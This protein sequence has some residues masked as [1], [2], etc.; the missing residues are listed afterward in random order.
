M[1][2]TKPAQKRAFWGWLWW[3][4]V[5]LFAVGSVAYHAWVSIQIR[6]NDYEMARCRR[7]MEAITAEMREVK[8]QMA[9][10]ED[11]DA[12]HAT[13]EEL[14]LRAP[15]PEQIVRLAFNPAEYVPVDERLQAQQPAPQET[16]AEAGAPAKKH[17]PQPAMELA[18]I[19]L[20]QTVAPRETG[21]MTMALD[22]DAALVPVNMNAPAASAVVE[23]AEHGLDGS[24]DQ[25]LEKF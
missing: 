6:N 10:R 12:V 11:M 16:P 5:L 20:R 2:M 19:E 25:M 1:R 15:R 17:K 4:P 3:S 18:K 22:Y 8:V 24:V 9:E 14:G 21:R 7:Q 13:A 23:T